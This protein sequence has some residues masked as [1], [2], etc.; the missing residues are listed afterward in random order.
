MLRLKQALANND[1]RAVRNYA[2]A[3]RD[4]GAVSGQKVI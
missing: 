4:L 1:S 2:Q 3:L